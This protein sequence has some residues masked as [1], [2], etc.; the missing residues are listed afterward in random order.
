MRAMKCQISPK[1]VDIRKIQNK[2]SNNKGK[3][4]SHKRITPYRAFSNQKMCLFLCFFQ[5]WFT[6]MFQTFGNKPLLWSFMKK[7]C[8]RAKLIWL[9]IK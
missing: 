1:P 5:Q 4:Y 9:V 6:H 3:K 8:N 2:N 7:T